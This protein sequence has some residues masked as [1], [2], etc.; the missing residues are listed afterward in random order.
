M[1]LTRVGVTSSVGSVRRLLIPRVVK[2]LRHLSP[3]I[4]LAVLIGCGNDPAAGPQ[5]FV[6][7]PDGVLVP[8]ESVP[9]ADASAPGD[10]GTDPS[11]GGAAD[12][13]EPGD[14]PLGTDAPPPPPDIGGVCTTG[15]D[16]PA[17]GEPCVSVLCVDGECVAEFIPHCCTSVD[18]CGDGDE[19]TKDRCNPATNKCSWEP[20]PGCGGCL[21]AGECEDGDPCTKH[22]CVEGECV[23]E[24]VPACCNDVAA[25]DDG[26]PCSEDVCL[27]Q[28]CQHI[29]KPECCAND[30]ACDDGVDCTTD[31]CEIKRDDGAGTCIHVKSGGCCDVVFGSEFAKDAELSDWVLNKPNTEIAWQLFDKR[32]KSPPKS[33]YMGNPIEANYINY[34][35]FNP[36]Q[37]L[38]SETWIRTPQFDVPNVGGK[39]TLEFQLWLDV[40]DCKGQSKDFDL[41]G[42]FVDQEA[43]APVPLM[44]KCNIEEPWK[45]WKK[46]TIDLASFKGHKIALRFDFHSVDAVENDGEG[47]YIDDLQVKA[48][49]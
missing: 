7:G 12:G 35:D 27:D 47:I 19:C 15:A 21:A 17:P 8:A 45:K 32:F 33:L 42:V 5:L 9:S 46:V 3:S 31:T 20:I 38:V 40:E 22:A 44:N 23:T 49:Y 29:P 43:Q 26:N 18:E 1:R 28:Q 11:D 36:Q 34:N 14:T 13:E 10:D 39:V 6:K 41:F 25:C 16:C 37:H 4:L 2:H 30:A 48:C 24:Q